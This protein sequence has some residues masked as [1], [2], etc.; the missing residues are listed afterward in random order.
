MSNHTK[1]IHDTNNSHSPVTKDASNSTKWNATP[2]NSTLS[3]NTTLS[4]GIDIDAD[5]NGAI[6]FTAGSN[7]SWST[8]GWIFYGNT[9]LYEGSS[10]SLISK[11]YGNNDTGVEGVWALTWNEA[12][13]NEG[14]PV[15]L[16]KVGETT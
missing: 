4:L 9:A 7:S 16:R 1:G 6:G 12:G 8:I 3:S 2:V 10:G 11:F 13:V 15:A 14:F 5:S